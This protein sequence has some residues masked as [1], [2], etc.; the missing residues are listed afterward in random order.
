MLL[1][2]VIGSLLTVSAQMIRQ[3]KEIEIL[4]TGDGFGS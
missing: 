4:T 1:L 2:A 3:R